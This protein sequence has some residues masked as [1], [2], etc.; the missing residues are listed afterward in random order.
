METRS[1]DLNPETIQRLEQIEQSITYWSRKHGVLTLQVD[2]A[3]AQL[4][5][6]YDSRQQLF[7]EIVQA[8]NFPKGT[9][10]VEILESGEIKIAL[11][12]S[13]PPPSDS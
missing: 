3:K 2:R 4:A 13:E 11:P 5:G 8:N 1:I 10:I 12:D 6:M 7:D 9:R